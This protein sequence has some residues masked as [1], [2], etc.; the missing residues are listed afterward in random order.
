MKGVAVVAQP[1]GRPLDSPELWPFYEKVAEFGVP[2]CIHPSGAPKGF[3]AL[4]AP[5]SLHGSIGRE[6]DLALAATRIIIGGVLEDF[7][8]LKI[9][10]SHL[11][12]GLFAIKE[13]LGLRW[14]ASS[15]VT[16][17]FE[18]YFGKLYFNMAG[19]G[20]GGATLE[21]ALA[22]VSPSRLVFGTD[23]PQNYK[24]DGKGMKA[25]IEKIRGLNLDEAAIKGILE[26]NAAELLR[27]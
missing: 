1:E 20:R 21:C 10:M 3:D 7:P 15:H 19:F 6:F 26:D 4:K 16:K 17:S 14:P 27:L 5:Y 12:G 8:D 22:A 23:Y 11:G 18:H 9:V 13:R 2:I 25:Y 24:G